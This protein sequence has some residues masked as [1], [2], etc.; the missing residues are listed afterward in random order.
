M[1]IL[2][3]RET[4][5]GALDLMTHNA[6]VTM[7][8]DYTDPGRLPVKLRIQDNSLRF[9]LTQ[10]DVIRLKEN[11]R[12]DAEVRFTADRAVRYFVAG[13]QSLED[14]EVE[15]TTDCV[16]VFLPGPWVLAWADSDQVSIAGRGRVQVLVEKDVQFRDRLPAC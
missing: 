11:G 15:Y 6:G 16:R 2:P 13:T 3:K 8:A 1:P 12:V 9:R 14:I 10:T 5:Q 4:H 7:T